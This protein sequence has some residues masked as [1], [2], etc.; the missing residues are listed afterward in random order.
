MLN[1]CV[2]GLGKIVFEHYVI[3]S[4]SHSI[5]EMVREGITDEEK[6]IVKMFGMDYVMV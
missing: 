1:I 2:N 5:N 6:V 4:F 3:A